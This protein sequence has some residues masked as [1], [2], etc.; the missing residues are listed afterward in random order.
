MGSNAAFSPLIPTLIEVTHEDRLIQDEEPSLD[1]LLSQL[2]DVEAADLI[3]EVARMNKE[4]ETE[5]AVRVARNMALLGPL[6]VERLVRDAH[7][8]E[9]FLRAVRKH[10]L[11]EY[12]S[13]RTSE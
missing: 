8:K 10:A 6:L 2:P 12:A 3:E 9:A 13:H 7:S 5:R 4:H 1:L 11:S